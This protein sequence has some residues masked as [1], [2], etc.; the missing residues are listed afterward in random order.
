PC[1]RIAGRSAS[2]HPTGGRLFF[3]G[4]RWTGGRVCASGDRRK[5]WRG[6][7]CADVCRRGS[8][9]A[10]FGKNGGNRPSLWILLRSEHVVLPGRRRCRPRPTAGDASCR[11]GRR[12]L[13]F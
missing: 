11:T 3:E 13:V 2:R 5:R 12:C 4:G 8:T 1:V 10:A 6:R 9:T 7:E